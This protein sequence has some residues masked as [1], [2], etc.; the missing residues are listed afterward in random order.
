VVNT[1]FTGLQTYTHLNKKIHIGQMIPQFTLA[2]H[3]TLV[4]MT[5][6][7]HFAYFNSI[8]KHQIIFGGNLSNKGSQ[9]PPRAV[10]LKVAAAET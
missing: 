5:H 9:S 1:K 10:V 7:F 4:V 6:S 3:F 8:M 2:W